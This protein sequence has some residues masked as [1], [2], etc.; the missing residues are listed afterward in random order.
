M[1]A[2]ALLVS[3]FLSLSSFFIPKKK[4]KQKEN[5]S[6][7]NKQT[8]KQTNKLALFSFLFFFLD[9]SKPGGHGLKEMA[10]TNPP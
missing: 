9:V 2:G 3:F 6:K 8:N 7:T 5:F 1:T 10:A 4:R